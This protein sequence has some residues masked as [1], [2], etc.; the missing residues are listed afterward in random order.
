MNLQG[1]YNLIKDICPTYHYES[2]S[3]EYPRQVYTEYATNYEYA[4]NETYEKKVS[5]NLN[6]Y[7]KDEFDKTERMLELLMMMTKD[8]TFN[9]ETSFDEETKITNNFYDIE[10]TETI[11]YEDLIKELEDLLNESNKDNKEDAY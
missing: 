8:I 3:E 2:D 5:I 10:I 9:K 4:S 1:F 7:S 11:S 6:H